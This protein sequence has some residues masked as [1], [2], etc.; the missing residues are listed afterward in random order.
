MS[1]PGSVAEGGPEKASEKKIDRALGL[2]EQSLLGPFFMQQ[3]VE[4]KY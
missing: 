2:E 4:M 3:L 1:R